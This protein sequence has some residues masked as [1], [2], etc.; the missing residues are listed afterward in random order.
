MTEISLW[1]S[2]HDAYLVQLESDALARW[3]RLTI[4]SL[5]LREFAQEAPELRWI[6]ELSEVTSLS[7][8]QWEA[9]PGSTSVQAYQAKGRYVS[10]DWNAFEKQVG[11]ETLS[12]YDIYD[13][14]LKPH[15][16]GVLLHLTGEI[17]ALGY[18]EISLVG[19]LLSA[20]RSDGVAITL[21]AFR[22]L[23]EAY[24]EAWSN[25]NHAS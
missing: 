21:E 12:I 25:R 6:L 24:W 17:N 2:L 7:T 22:H 14:S 9:W 10:Y 11:A 19:T 4:D 15:D 3:V 1:A 20:S 23:G 13:A 18:F 5:H 16:S 8:L